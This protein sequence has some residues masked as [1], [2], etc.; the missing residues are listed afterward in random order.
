MERL[1]ALAVRA[2][3]CIADSYVVHPALNTSLFLGTHA[4]PIE[5]GS[6][7]AMAIAGEEAPTVTEM[8]A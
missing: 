8:V 1:A 3:T 7:E 2:S 6:T 4:P 5:P